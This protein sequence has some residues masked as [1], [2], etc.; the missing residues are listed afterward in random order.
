MSFCSLCICEYSI[1]YEK[2]NGA[3][4]YDTLSNLIISNVKFH[5]IEHLWIL[6]TPVHVCQEHMLVFWWYHLHKCLSFMYMLI[7]FI[8]IMF[9]K[10]TV[11]IVLVIIKFAIST[12]SGKTKEP[13]SLTGFYLVPSSEAHSTFV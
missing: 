9:I 8:D 2:N 4:K 1:L 11:S 10:Y 6:I 7:F 5:E 3:V 12:C 13:A